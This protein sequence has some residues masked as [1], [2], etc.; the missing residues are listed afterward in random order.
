[1]KLLFA[2]VCIFLGS[3]LNASII[4]MRH[5]EAQHNVEDFYNTNPNHPNYRP[6]SLTEKGIKQAKKTAEKLR[7]LG[8]KI[9]ATQVYVSPLPRTLQTA[10]A[11]IK[12]G[13][14]T[15]EAMAIDQRLIEMQMGD[16]EGR[17]C[18]DFPEDPW[19]RTFAKEYNGETE[20]QIMHRIQ[21]IF[22]QVLLQQKA[23]PEKHFVLVTHG[24]PALALLKIAYGYE[25]KLGHA[26]FKVI[27]PAGIQI[28]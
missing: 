6:V 3:E 28:K 17:H 12:V 2:V 8:L 1:M 18:S 24:W 10:Q 26:E 4:V 20:E 7:E 25:V 23:N 15:K 22:Q 9:E 13:I 14:V 21:N 11:L 27:E 5:G 16:R 19:D